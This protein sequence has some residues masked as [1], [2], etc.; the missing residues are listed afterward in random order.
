MNKK[1]AQSILIILI[2]TLAVAFCSIIW[3][4]INLNFSN[5]TQ[6]TGAITQQ[7]YSTDAD[8]L[9][10]VIFILIP[11]TAFLISFYFLKK[12]K[13]R[14]FEDLIKFPELEKINYNVL[15]PVTILLALIF[16]QF[17]SLN[18]PIGPIDTFHDGELFSV[19]KNTIHKGSFFKDTYTIHGF[20]DIFYPLIFWKITGLETIGSGRLFFFFLSLLIK[21]LCLGLSYQ[22]IRF[23]KVKNK[24]IFFIIFSLILLTFSDYQVPINFS[25]FS[26]E[27]FI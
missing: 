24:T 2:T 5:V 26:I 15:L 14:N 3:Q 10:Y 6:A 20:S 23:S 22:L 9:R 16:F 11:L 17:L 4:H 21:I 19:A 1:K 18:L 13:T 25:L 12:S 7:N 8:T 27:I